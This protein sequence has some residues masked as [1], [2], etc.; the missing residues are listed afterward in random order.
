MLHGC[1]T[2]KRDVTLT[3]MQWLANYGSAR[4]ILGALLNLMLLEMSRK[5]CFNRQR[6]VLPSWYYREPSQAVVD[7]W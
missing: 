7:C 5:N 6:R 4:T 1:L 2:C 3:M